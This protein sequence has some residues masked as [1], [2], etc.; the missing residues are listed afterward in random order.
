MA[1]PPYQAPAD[2]ASYLEAGDYQQSKTWTDSLAY[3]VLG[4]TALYGLRFGLNSI[5]I[6]MDPRKLRYLQE[7]LGP[8]F[9]GA[10]G[11][12]P[13][14]TAKVPLRD[15]LLDKIKWVEESI[16]GLRRTFGVF[17]TL[18]TNTLTRGSTELRITGA[19]A[20]EQS[21]ELQKILGRQLTVQEL[22][23]GFHLSGY[24]EDLLR[25]TF[26][27]TADDLLRQGLATPG[28]R[29]GLFSALEGG[30]RGDLLVPDIDIHAA[31]W[32]PEGVP[33]AHRQIMTSARDRAEMM[34]TRF[35]PSG[36]SPYQLAKS[37]GEVQI[38]GVMREV[39]SDFTTDIAKVEGML[40]RYTSPGTQRGIEQASL[41][42][43]RL[44]TR[45]LK[46]L[47]R[48]LETLEEVFNK[49]GSLSKASES[50]PYRLF[51]DVLGTGGNYSG[52]MADLLT[53][54]AGRLAMVGIAG[55]AVYEA[56][57]AVT[58]LLT[59]RNLAQV[60]GEAVGATQRLYAS[61]SDVTGLTAL[62]KYQAEEAEGSHRLLG[63]LA[64]P[65]SGYITGRTGA[66]FT[67][68]VAMQE[69]E[70][71][72]RFAREATHELPEFLRKVPG[73]DKMG[74]MTRGHKYGVVGAAI[75]A[76]LSAP[77]LLGA[78]G[79]EKSYSEVVEE[80][81]G[82]TEVAVRKGAGWEAGRTDIKGG[83]IQYF[84]QGWY[85]NL[86]NDATGEMMYDDLADRPFSR[87]VRDVT[88]PY[89]REKA[90]YKERPYPITGP[91]TSGWGPLGSLWG[92]TIGRVIKP[93][94]YMH[95]EEA[96]PGGLGGVGSGEVARYGLSAGTAPIED[97]GGLPAEAAVSPYSGSFQAGE[98]MY[99][100]TEA[101]GLPGFAFSAVKR[102]FTGSQDF[103]DEN[104]VLASFAGVG[105]LR[106]RFWD[107]NV[108][109]GLTTT[110]A[111]RRLIPPER[112]Q[113]QKINPIRNLMPSWMPGSD[114]Y[115]DFKHGDPYQAIQ[116]GEQRLPGPAF[117]AK[118]PELEG[119]DYEDYPDIYKYKILSDVAPYS[120]EL[121][122]VSKRVA[123]EAAEGGLSDSQH[124][125]YKGSQ[126][127]LE[128]KKE[129]VSTRKEPE[130]LIGAYW[131]SLVKA[132]RMNPVEHLWPVSP[133]HKFAGPTDPMT[134]YALNR[135][136]SVESP[137]WGSPVEDF[138]KPALST[139]AYGMGWEGIPSQVQ[140]RNEI[141]EY[142]DKLE[143]MKQ[144]RLAE[145][146]GDE[147]LPRSA[148]TYNRRA[149]RTMYGAN[150]Y[151]EIQDILPILSSSDRD[152]FKTFA[153]EADP[154]KRSQILNMTPDYMNKFFEA[155]WQKQ[156][157]AQ[158]S[159][160]P[161][162]SSGDQETLDRI[163][164]LRDTQGQPVTSSVVGDYKDQLR[165]GNLELTEMP[166]Y[167]RDR[168]LEEYFEDS[169]YAPPPSDWTGW[170]P[171][172]A[173]E[174]VKLR[175][176]EEEGADHHDFDIWEDQKALARRKPYL[177]EPAMEIVH[178]GRDGA[179]TARGMLRG[180][181]LTGVDADVAPNYGGRNRV[182]LDVRRDNRRALA[183]EF[184][185][186]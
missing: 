109:G 108:G 89:W 22:E 44:T 14:T 166:N 136:H 33:D 4:G 156:L 32:A 1:L 97:L 177:D 47:D 113:L 160:N 43:K 90:F 101:V 24:T 176:I 185:A 15:I 37:T 96:S 102:A 149:S 8:S 132:G 99:K 64:F 106:D 80:Q 130:S 57:S 74:P 104:P 23:R 179:S 182:L 145:K 10:A 146:A 155:Q 98:S 56:G 125:L 95:T 86:M 58:N 2:R 162:V 100:A 61:A 62:N 53:R 49:P 150:P 82:E 20:L 103:E 54:H 79:S 186:R 7:G 38:R 76:V 159:A 135:I 19:Q 173:L 78:F 107:S 65:L 93:E 171:R 45:Y 105:S 126:H 51:R 39:L 110:E 119:V 137:Y 9:S 81:R 73:F 127:Q 42:S 11:Y 128:L 59:D 138:I 26:P 111:L 31:R 158:I 28:S 67:H 94:A 88:D 142:F 21:S 161:D 178:G 139:A 16:G 116:R 140:E 35:D 83:R 17:E 34:G 6:E 134:S 92:A 144:R 27:D 167:L 154:E 131:G 129:R 181:G 124:E 175:V 41:I 13:S 174:D 118:F 122:Q 112:F 75:G 148:F 63:V 180:Q 141:N 55:A 165:S 30:V 117:E 120:Q 72:W 69:G 114:Y 70:F 91:D 5:T 3:L 123:Q 143:Y 152:Y 164:A 170:D 87:M 121:R 66:A 163:D 46:M 68:R 18:A 52:N 157:Y 48:P 40:S 60:G 25:Q 168:R 183:R 151:A 12:G 29:P 36:K 153:L 71:A 133:V 172:V 84:D 85:A 147:G 115:T 77:F 184:G 50:R 169:R